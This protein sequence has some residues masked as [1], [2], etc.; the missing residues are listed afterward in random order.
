MM[1]KANKIGNTSRVP[2]KR[3]CCVL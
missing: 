2:G 1:H 3:V